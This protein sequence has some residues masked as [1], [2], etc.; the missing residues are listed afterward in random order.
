MAKGAVLDIM[1]CETRY[2]GCMPPGTLTQLR[3]GVVGPCIL[4]LLAGSPRYGLE[5]VR[6][7]DA[8][9]GL[10][11]SHGTLYPLLN[12]LHEAG[13]VSSRWELLAGE[14]RRRYYGITDA[15]RQERIAF[16]EDWGSF[17]AAVGRVLST[18][19]EEGADRDEQ[20]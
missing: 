10:L 4:A 7:L 16:R 17:A 12:R 13:L 11:T 5:L 14:R 2:S 1:S 18:E 19:H 8:I 20:R 3:R 9:G 6:E 15:G